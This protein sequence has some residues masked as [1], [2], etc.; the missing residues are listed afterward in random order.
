MK[1]LGG[2][3]TTWLTLSVVA[4]SGIAHAGSPIPVTECKQV[5]DVAGG[6]YVLTA[7]VGLASCGEIRGPITIAAS[8][9]A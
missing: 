2:L 9:F 5:L 1:M 8:G 3:A 4:V 6:E 7:S